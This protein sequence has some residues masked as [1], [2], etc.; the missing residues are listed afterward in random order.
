[1]PVAQREKRLAELILYICQQLADDPYFGQTKLNKVLFF[2][3]F[4]AY[5]KWGKTLSGGEYQH[6][7]QGPCVRR[8]KPVQE[9]MIE[10]KDLELQ[11]VEFHSFCQERL[12]NLR[13]PNLE[14]FTRDEIAL[15]DNWIARLRIMSAKEAS[16]LSHQ[17]A[18]WQM[19]KQ[20]ELIDPNLVFIAWGAPTNEEI[21]RGQEIAAQHSLLT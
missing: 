13:A 12:V 18:A 14:L 15:I 3:D 4:D 17:T 9:A 10:A 1:M 11:A 16:E 2:A 20:G 6:I 19:T 21:R 7:Q 5:G 8:M